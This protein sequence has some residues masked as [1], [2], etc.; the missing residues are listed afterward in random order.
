MLSY[1]EV[2]FQN[3]GQISLWVVV[4]ETGVDFKT[5]YNGTMSVRLNNK[6]KIRF[7]M[8]MNSMSSASRDIPKEL[9]ISGSAGLNRMKAEVPVRTGRLKK[10]LDA[11]VSGN[12]LTFESNAPYSLYVEE[13]TRY[14]NAQPFFFKNARRATRDFINRSISRINKLLR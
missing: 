1:H 4:T 8:L 11:E 9:P 12:K 7:K 5:K 2:V 13:G 3:R 10:G 14:T 6:D